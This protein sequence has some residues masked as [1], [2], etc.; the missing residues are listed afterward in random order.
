MPNKKRKTKM[1][2]AAVDSSNK[3]KMQKASNTDENET[4]NAKTTK[5]VE[6]KEYEITNTHRLMEP[7]PVILVV[8][9]DAG[10]RP[11][12]M[13]MGFHLP[14]QHEPP[15][16]GIILGPW[17]FSYQALKKTGECVIAIPGVDLA[18]KVV[19]IG[20]CSGEDVDKFA[21]FGLSSSPASEVSPP[22]INECLANIECKVVDK[23]MVKKYN[24]WILSPVKAW[25]NL[26]R[27][28]KRTFHHKGDGTFVVDGETIDLKER[29]VKW[30]E[31]QD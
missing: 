27:K 2:E 16:V 3:G 14:M 13:T 31:Y 12:I 18:E 26:E 10:K 5:I 8:T 25:T 20:N 7:G 30:K 17:D 1:D 15:L 24:M 29:M 11:N 21:K 6:M 22:L 4:K 9:K 19:D 23:S 28:E